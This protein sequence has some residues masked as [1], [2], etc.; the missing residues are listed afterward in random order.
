MLSRECGRRQWECEGW[1]VQEERW[2]LCPFVAG[3][4]VRGAVP[5]AAWAGGRR[6]AGPEVLACQR[7]EA[8]PEVCVVSHAGRSWCRWQWSC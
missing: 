4:L 1:Y 8:P 7:Q 2:I 6:L 5:A 3:R